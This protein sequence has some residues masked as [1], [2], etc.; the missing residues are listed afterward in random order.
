MCVCERELNLS[1]SV[2]IFVVS[3]GVWLS[4]PLHFKTKSKKK[5]ECGAPAERESE[6]P[7]HQKGRFYLVLDADRSSI[8]SFGICLF[9]FIYIFVSYNNLL[10]ITNN[11]N[12]SI[13]MISK[14]RTRFFFLF[15][16]KTKYIHWYY[17][18]NNMLIK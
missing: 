11:A 17:F 14:A 4:S 12:N 9:F 16:L 1:F 6:E 7:P 5:S 8:G 15:I 13:Q 3:A 10:D 2:I 18:V